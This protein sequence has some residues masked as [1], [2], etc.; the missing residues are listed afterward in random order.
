MIRLINLKNVASYKSNATLETDKKINLIYGLNGA[1]KSTF[2]NFFHQR[3]DPKYK[4][5]SIDGLED[6]HEVLVYNQNF[7]QENFFEVENLKGIFTLSKENKEAETK[8][9]D[10]LK[11]IEKL[12]DEVEKQKSELE[13]E[14]R[15]I[16][17]E[18]N[19]A[20][21]TVW[22]IKNDYSG[23]DRVLEFCLDGYKGSKDSLFNYLLGLSKP[24]IKPQKSI[25]DLKSDFQSI[26]GDNPQKYLSLPK[27]NFSSQNVEIE[28]LFSKHIV[29]NENSTVSQLIKM[30]GNSDWVK[31]G[32]KYIP[33]DN[34]NE[35]LNCPFCQEKT[36]SNILIENIKSYFDASYEADIVAL[37]YLFKNYSQEIQS[38]PN[39]STFESHPKFEVYSKDF[40]IRYHEFIKII[41]NN[42]K[43]IEDKIKNP[44]ISVALKSSV[45]A[46]EELNKV[47]MGINILVNEHN[48]NIEQKEVVKAN[49]RKSFWEI[50]CWEYDL[51]ISSFKAKKLISQSKIEKIEENIR[52][53]LIKID[54]QK[55]II[56]E[57]QKKTVNIEGAIEN[58]KNGLI[59]LGIND[60]EIKKYS[61][62][63][64]KI[65]RGDKEDR[66]FHSL[67]EGEK[68]IISFLYFLELCRGKKEV[69]ATSTKKI[70]V[71]DDPISSLSHIYVFNVGRLI[72]NEFFGKKSTRVNPE[73]SCS[74]TTWNYKYE[75]VFI[76]T[77]SLYF[78][79]EVTETNHDVR[80][81]TQSLFRLVKNDTGSA[82]IP[83]KYE[84]IQND[85]QAYWFIIRD[86]QQP[87]ALIAN[88][89]RNVIEYF[90][91]FV[92][93]KDLNNFFQLGELSSNRYQAFYRYI[94]R[95]S[96]SLGQNIFDFKEFNYQD[97]RDAFAELFKVAGYE[98]HY[99]K[100]IAI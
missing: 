35:N 11:E 39:K 20:K 94:N 63:F 37:N 27:I 65:V 13:D 84:E 59:E 75:Q 92:E 97:F 83:M 55:T 15:I 50:M 66:I 72:K 34:L 82:F 76:L 12:K 95:E 90:F 29:G 40:E 14:K 38:I 57:Q 32:L 67:S 7:I 64:Y 41:E 58:I 86:S 2:S 87:A 69:T 45:E 78:F 93:K 19:A 8:I 98:K 79:Y 28:S 74:E 60:F 42:Q 23:G 77:H 33:Q 5:C 4:D 1:G 80:K 70:I 81:E 73:T 43:I 6:D 25:D 52:Q 17:Q 49:I 36:I 21:E 9:S 10:A 54:I 51:T 30:L 48:K 62:N 91:N 68:M 61:D 26:S 3:V 24:T 71:I 56:S 18:Q 100:M 89:M 99:K 47:I 31:A 85:Y 44:S 22:K 53:N 16:V 96:H 88:C 46:L